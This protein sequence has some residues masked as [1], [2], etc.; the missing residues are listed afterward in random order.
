V[1]LRFR[2]LRETCGW[3]KDRV[4]HAGPAGRVKTNKQTKPQWKF[5]SYFNVVGKNTQFMNT[6]NITLL[7]GC[8]VLFWNVVFHKY[9]FGVAVKKAQFGMI[10]TS[11]LFFL[12][13]IYAKLVESLA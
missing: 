4:S 7:L 10:I 13:T 11:S 3:L 2:N 6:L 12:E 8:F 9:I 1:T 5:C